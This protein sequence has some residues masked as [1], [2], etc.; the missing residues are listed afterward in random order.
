ML[1]TSSPAATSSRAVPPVEINS[2]P[3]STRPR[4][5]STIPVLSETDSSARATR[6][7]PGAVGSGGA[8]ALAPV[9]V[10]SPTDREHTRGADA[11]LRAYDTWRSRPSQ[12]G[13]RRSF[14]RIFPAP[15][16]GRASV[17]NSTD[18]GSL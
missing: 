16:F 12:Y 8:S 13:D 15:D 6:T 3:S 17:R 9:S 1:R 2:T 4:A 11:S 7:S 18:R 10:V 14:L 5:K